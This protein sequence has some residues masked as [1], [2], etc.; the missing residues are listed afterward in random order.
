M[1]TNKSY[2]ILSFLG[3]ITQTDI[4]TLLGWEWEDEL[5]HP[6]RESEEV[7]RCLKTGNI[8]TVVGSFE[9]GKSVIVQHIGLKYRDDHWL[10]KPVDTLNQILEISEKKEFV[11]GL[12]L[13]V[14]NDPIG[15]WKIDEESYSYWRSHEETLQRFL[16]NNNLKLLLYCRK[17]ILNYAEVKKLVHFRNVIN[18][19]ERSNKLTEN[20]NERRHRIKMKSH[21]TPS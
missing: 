20:E 2:V 12:T 9:K 14:L 5:F 7:E 13:F 6:T 4:I 15:K 18:V 3:L 1:N 11:P 16:Q 8:V 17:P 21:T 10:V 19:D